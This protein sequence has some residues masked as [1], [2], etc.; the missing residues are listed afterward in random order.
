MGWVGLGRNANV[1]AK[2]V[3]ALHGSFVIR[4]VGGAGRTPGRTD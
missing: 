1:F 2:S 4:E 3:N